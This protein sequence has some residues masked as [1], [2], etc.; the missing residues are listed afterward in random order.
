MMMTAAG[1]VGPAR[2]LIIGVG[3]AGLQAI[4]TAKRLGAAVSA[5]DVRAATKEQVESLGAK[6]VYPAAALVDKEDKSG[7]AQEVTKDFAALQD[8][9]LLSIIG[10]FD[11]VITTAQIPGKKAPILLTKK[12][13]SGMKSGSVIVD[14]AAGSGGNVEDSVIDKIVSKKGVKIIGWANMAARI[15]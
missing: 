15:A 6:F 8:A 9:F 1:T 12:M 2:A 11:I 10:N 3:V 5:Y 7:Y 13:V 4:A 14:I